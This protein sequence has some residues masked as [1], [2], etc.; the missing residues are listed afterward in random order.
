MIDDR[1][2]CNPGSDCELTR[3]A[4]DSFSRHSPPLDLPIRFRNSS[5]DACDHSE[6]FLFSYDLHRLYAKVEGRPRILVNPAVQVAYEDQWFYWNNTLL[7]YP[8]IRWWRSK[9]DHNTHAAFA[10]YQAYGVRESRFGFS[11][12][13]LSGS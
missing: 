2:Y 11:I 4:S 8:I 13:R 12:D 3:I 5:I 7:R 9:S 1:Q 10:D 6:S